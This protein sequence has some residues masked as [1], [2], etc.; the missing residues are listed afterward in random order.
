MRIR[1]EQCERDHVGEQ[2]RPDAAKHVRKGNI[3]PH[4][5][6]YETTNAHRLIG[7]VSRPMPHSLTAMMP[8]QIGSAQRRMQEG[9]VDGKICVRV[10]A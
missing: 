8:N 4:A 5:D 2:E 1:G 9:K 3:R 10:D 7:G 6:D